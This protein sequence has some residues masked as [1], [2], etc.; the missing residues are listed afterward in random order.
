MA[1][2]PAPTPLAPGQ[3]PAVP[4]YGFI[5]PPAPPAALL[6]PTP[7]APGQV[8][9]VPPYG[10]IAPPMPPPVLA[11]QEKFQPIRHE[12]EIEQE[13][14]EADHQEEQ[15]QEEQEATLSE[16][17][18]RRMKV[19][20]SSAHDAP[21]HYYCNGLYPPLTAHVACRNTEQK[22]ARRREALN[23]LFPSLSV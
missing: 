11:A 1:R 8:P 4:P 20:L 22:A 15:E 9:A 17:D 10:F 23:L 18:A 14:D 6:R 19:V 5:A 21:P 2:P 13:I 16:E 12:Q 7:L 3:T